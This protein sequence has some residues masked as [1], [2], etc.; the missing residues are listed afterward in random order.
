VPT[1]GSPKP[2]HPQVTVDGAGRV[3]VAWD[4]VLDGVRTAAYVVG[5]TAADGRLRFGR[6]ARLAAGPTA[7]PVMAAAGRGVLAAWT[8]G[9]PTAS[10]VQLRRIDAGDGTSNRAR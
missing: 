6:P 1:L 5:T 8:A 9:P 7:Y 4:E 3:V 2:S 10:T